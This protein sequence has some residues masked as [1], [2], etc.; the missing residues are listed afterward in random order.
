MPGDFNWQPEPDQ[1]PA[2][3]KRR[4]P[5]PAMYVFACVLAFGMLFL[6]SRGCGTSSIAPD[7]VHGASS[8]SAP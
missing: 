3:E 8:T 5:S 4:E 2:A 7:G 6:A 1:R